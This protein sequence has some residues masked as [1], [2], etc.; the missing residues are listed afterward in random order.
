MRFGGRD[1]VGG[2]LFERSGGHLA[3][4]FVNTLD[5]RRTGAPKERLRHFDDLVG[6]AVQAGALAAEVAPA[7][8]RGG[9]REPRGAAR[10][11]R[12]ARALR[13]H[14]FSLFCAAVDRQPLPRLDLDALNAALIGAAARR[15]LEPAGRA[16]RWTLANGRTPREV[17]LPP[18]ALAAGELLT[19][20]AL[21]RLRR[22]GGRGCAWLFL[23]ESRNGSRRWCDMTVCGNRAKA[24]RHRERQRGGASPPCRPRN[25]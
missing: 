11:L 21:T 24:A 8:R 7:L 15:R 13:E 2:W 20:P 1:S 23:D 17:L 10:C 5:E 22:C 19:S 6:F 4:D 25:E 9:A 16:A 3:L 14:L 12:E 18:L